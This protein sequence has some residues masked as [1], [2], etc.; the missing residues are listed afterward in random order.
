MIKK[1][2]KEKEIKLVD[3]GVPNL[4]EHFKNGVINGCNEVCGKG[5]QDAKKIQGGE[6]KK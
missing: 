4:W 3:I 1:R 5:R 2:Y 6:I